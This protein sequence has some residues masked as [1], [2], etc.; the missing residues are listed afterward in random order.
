MSVCIAA[1]YG[2]TSAYC[3][4]TAHAHVWLCF[5]FRQLYYFIFVFFLALCF[6]K[7]LLQLKYCPVYAMC[8]TYV[9]RLFVGHIKVAA[10][11][12]LTLVRW[13]VGSFH[14]IQV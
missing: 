2:A 6:C 10:F 11:V 8:V 13:F 12:R 5:S 4:S 14:G 7:K 9:A 3:S 1:I